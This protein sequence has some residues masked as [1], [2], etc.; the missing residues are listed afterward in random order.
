MAELIVIG[1]DTTERAEAARSELFGL[2]KEYLVEV[3]DAVVAVR[4]PNG[5]IKLN[6]MVNLWTIGAAG[7]SFWGL[8]AGLLFFNPL[9]GVV[10]GAAAGAVAG[11]LNDYGISDDFMRQ[12]ADVLQPGQAALFIL[13]NRVSSERVIDGIAKHGGRVLR[14]NL[15]TSQE[16]K[17][18]EAF[19][20][21]AK[22]PEVQA[23]AAGAAAPDTGAATVAE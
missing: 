17:L 15:D 22:A 20:K 6:Q 9:L 5:K 23:A 11:A 2:S 3:G 12:V 8:L 19:E 10:T 7:G 13:A 1:Y 18:R 14:T 21:A 16:Q 4:E